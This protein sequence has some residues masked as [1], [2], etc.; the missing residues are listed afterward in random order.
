MGVTYFRYDQKMWKM[1]SVRYFRME[2]CLKSVTIWHWNSSMDLNVF[3]QFYNCHVFCVICLFLST[4]GLT[5]TICSFSDWNS[6][7]ERFL[8]RQV[9][10]TREK[11]DWELDILS[12]Y[13]LMVWAISWSAP[14]KFYCCNFPIIYIRFAFVLTLNV[15]VLFFLRNIWLKMMQDNN[16]CEYCEHS[17]M[18]ILCSSVCVKLM[19][20]L[21]FCQEE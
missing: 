18:E 12:R 5:S 3:Y 2:V 13:R 16:F 14:S 20:L 19:I 9:A 10:L 8:P 1:I 17:L 6:L 11:R 7:L 21:D 4:N 15:F